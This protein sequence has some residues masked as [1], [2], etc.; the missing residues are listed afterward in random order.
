MNETSCGV[1]SDDFF[2]LF[3]E[4]SFLCVL[5][6]GWKVRVFFSENLFLAHR[7]AMSD[8]SENLFLAHRHEMADQSE[9]LFRARTT[10]PPREGRPSSYA[11]K[12]TGF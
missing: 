5:G 1:I 4:L 6:G 2:L 9:N 12:G 3:C 10:Q 8:R 7:H 11:H